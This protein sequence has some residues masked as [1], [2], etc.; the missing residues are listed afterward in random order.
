MNRNLT[1]CR[2]GLE[3]AK[4]VGA[5]KEETTEVA[6]GHQILPEQARCFPRSH[7]GQETDR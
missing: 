2:V 3:Q 5:N 1:F 4:L 7:T 6:F